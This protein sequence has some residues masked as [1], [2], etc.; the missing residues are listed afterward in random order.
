MSLDKELRVMH[1]CEVGA[2]GVYRGHKCIARY[3]YRS[4]IADLD[5]MRL[6]EKDHSSIFMGL[7]AHRKIRPCFAYKLFFLGGVVYG[8]L[9][10]LLGIKA[11]GASTSAIEGVVNIEI[12]AALEKFK[13][14][15]RICE[16][17]RAIQLEERQHQESGEN[18]AGIDYVL[19]RPIQR[20]ARV[21]AYAAK[22]I[23]L[24][25]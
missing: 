4:S 19:H 20:I 22:K 14:E 3:F 10:G 8:A 1:A 21:G 24:L 16:L 25:L 2:T 17:L 23:A 18:L 12:E 9:V 7:L 11:I 13:D 6:H 15:P 5:N